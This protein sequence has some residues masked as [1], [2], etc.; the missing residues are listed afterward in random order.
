METDNRTEKVAI[1]G[2]GIMGITLGYYL[3]QSGVRIEIY[4]ASPGLGGL[5]GPLEL[6]DGTRVDR[7]YHA[8][9]S[10]DRH[11][12]ELCRDLNIQS[13]LR[14]K[15]TRMGFYHQGEI[16]P[17]N[18]LLDF[19]RFRPLTWLDRL[20]LGV[21]ILNAMA[22]HDYHRLESVPVDRWLIRTGGKRAFEN[23][24][25]PM[26]RAK[27]DGD[28]G[29]TPATYIWE[30]LVRMRST[31]KGASQ[32]ELS[33]HLI[34]GYA[35]LLSAMATRIQA[36]GGG[37]HLR[38]PVS[39]IVIERGRA[40][41]IR[42]PD[43]DYLPFRSVIA[44]VQA[45]IFQRLIPNAPEPYLNFLNQT[46]YLG[47]LCP[48]LVLNQP[49]SGY[50]TLNITDDRIPFTGVIETTSYIDPQYV[51]G[52]HLVYL[53]KY[54][55]PGSSWQGYS[56]DEIRA[57]WLENLQVMFPGFTPN[58]I[59]Y[60]LVHRERFV[61]PIHRIDGSAQIP[62]IDTPVSGLHLVTTAQIYPQLTNGESVTRHARQ[63]AAQIALTLRN[64]PLVEP[65]SIRVPESS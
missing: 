8:I 32:K 21:T 56:D 59:R 19:L 65:G 49:L 7:F 41:G 64:P 61:E 31:R 50:W 45:P 12:Q 18:H 38:A 37:I 9:L 58:R 5:A 30:R 24:W 55:A 26:L 51:G 4:E 39:E 40:A 11:L 57:I 20:R 14:F 16:T 34:G 33:G 63:A 10:S 3:S 17:M 36:A 54:T 47:I 2:G 60:F 13:E 29:H 43:G 6:A 28:F 42:L 25:R 52:H 27:F 62:A 46:Q 15:E 53:P 23:L 35:T 44:T 22:I 48:L 1:I